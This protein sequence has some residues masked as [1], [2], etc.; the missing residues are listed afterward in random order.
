M[1]RRSA[2][3]GIIALMAALTWPGASHAA[4]AAKPATSAKTSSA[5]IARGRY[6]AIVG[7]CHDCHTH[8]FA[9][10]AGNVPESQWLRGSAVGFYGPWGTTY[11]P[12]LRFTVSNL[13]EAQWVTFARNLQVR[14]PM[15]WF[16]LNRWTDQDLRALYQYIRSLGPVGPLAP[17]FV[18]PDKQP[19]QP[20]IQWPAPPK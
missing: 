11:A 1:K 16:T 3:L 4:D 20:F 10:R 2:H 15:P 19:S 13:T 6:L 12:N 17:P 7:N 14:P 8:D 5:Q 9:E 18:P